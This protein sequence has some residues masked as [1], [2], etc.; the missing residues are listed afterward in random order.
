MK[1]IKN[2]ERII[3]NDLKDIVKKYPYISAVKWIER[4]PDEALSY[5]SAGRE[6]AKQNK[7]GDALRCYNEAISK[8]SNNRQFLAERAKLNG[9]KG[10]V[11]SVYRDLLSMSQLEELKGLRQRHLKKVLKEVTF[12]EVVQRYFD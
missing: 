6:L 8:E 12:I 3:S 5:V 4:L 2:T 7:I 10:D 11:D 1:K 9:L